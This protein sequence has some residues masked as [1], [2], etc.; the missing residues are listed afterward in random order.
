MLDNLYNKTII[1]ASQSPRRRELMEML[2]INFRVENIAGINEDYPENLHVN[3][4]PLF[5]ASQKQL[6]YK[7]LWSLHNHIV[8]TAD[9]IVSIENHI[10]GKPV[11]KNDAIKMLTLLSGKTHQVITGV[12]IKSNVKTVEFTAITD[13]TFKPMT[14]D[15]I[16]YYIDNYNPLDKAGAYGIQE[17]IGLTSISGINGSY[18]NVMGL[19]VDK[20]VDELKNFYDQKT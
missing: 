6:A 15:V 17:W 20:L 1:L 14:K 19:P 12:C 3:D 16:N 9:T 8:I 7:H 18:F 10:L 4:I 13:V 2:K 5:I 11:D